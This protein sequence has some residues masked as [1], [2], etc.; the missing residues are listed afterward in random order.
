VYTCDVEAQ[1]VLYKQSLSQIKKAIIG[2]GLDISIAIRHDS[3]RFVFRDDDIVVIFAEDGA[4]VNIA[5]FLKSQKVI[6]IAT[7][8]RVC[9]RLMQLSCEEFVNNAKS[10]LEAD[11]SHYEK[12]SI[13]RAQTSQG[14]SIE[15]VN[16]F[17]VGHNDQRSSRYS[18]LVNGKLYDQV[19]SGVAISTGTGSSGWEKSIRRGDTHY[20]ERGFSD[21]RV[22][23]A[24]RELCYGEYFAPFLVADSVHIISN[25]EA[26]RVFADG[27]LDDDCMLRLTPG[28]TVTITPNHRHVYMYRK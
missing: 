15:A 1:D 19:S 27:V 24:T 8:S 12:V 13:A 2:C 25:D 23:V 7:T 16:D 20:Q 28:A 4:F 17:L 18:L 11:I 10:V 9:G 6:T 5:K 3:H 21:R 22:C 26:N 14:Q